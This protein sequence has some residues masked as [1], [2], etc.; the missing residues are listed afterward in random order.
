ML[1]N[2][3]N[4]TRVALLFITI[5]GIMANSIFFIGSYVCIIANVATIVHY[6]SAIIFTT[7]SVVL[8]YYAL[9]LSAQMI[10]YSS[11]KYCISDVPRD[12]LILTDLSIIKLIGWTWFCLIFI[13]DGLMCLGTISVILGK[14][15]T[16]EHILFCGQAFI[17]INI[18]LVFHVISPFSWI[19][20]VPLPTQ[21]TRPITYAQLNAVANNKDWMK[22][23]AP[24]KITPT[25]KSF[26]S[27]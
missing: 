22:V 10:E 7:T 19:S 9:M 26:W 5:F 25:K 14:P 2:I 18:I 12:H 27:K 15:I 1:Q 11:T 16:D 6:T 8:N 23:V 3:A 17:I 13:C 24:T 4:R 21:P 20:K